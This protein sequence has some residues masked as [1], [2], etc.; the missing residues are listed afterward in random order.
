MPP[1]CPVFHRHDDD[2]GERDGRGRVSGRVALSIETTG[3]KG[4]RKRRRVEGASRSWMR[5]R[6]RLLGKRLQDVRKMI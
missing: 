4:N 6:V 5:E 1:S 2:D 3:M